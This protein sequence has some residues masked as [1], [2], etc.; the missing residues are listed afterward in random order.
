MSFKNWKHRLFAQQRKSILDKSTDLTVILTVWK[1]NN[2]KEQIEALLKQTVLPSQIWVYQCKDYLRINKYLKNYPF[3]ETFHS[4]VNLKY[5][6]RHT[7]AQHVTTTYTWILDDDII[8]SDT[9]IETCLKTCKNS[10]AIVC[11][12]GRIIPPNDFYPGVIKNQNY[13]EQYFIGDGIT[14]NGISVCEKDTIVDYGCSSFF[15]KTVWERCFWSI[16]PL[17]FQ[18]G[19][20]IHLSAACKIQKN[21]PTIVPKQ[22]SIADTGN[23]KPNYSFDE[24][25]SWKKEGFNAERAEV[26]KYLIE[27]K[28][29]NPVLWAQH[30]NGLVS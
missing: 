7:L 27:E 4:T 23:S 14:V 29:W 19:E 12:S 18:N 6:G 16:W 3:V 17:T 9:W 8:P 28:G 5:F 25:A 30:Q 24:Y 10:N 22:T 11:R 20:D 2:L 15:F 13:L 26:I 21:I 1:R